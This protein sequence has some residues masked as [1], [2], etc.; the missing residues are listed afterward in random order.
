MA[1]TDDVRKADQRGRAALKRY[2]HAVAA[3]FASGKVTIK[4]SNGAEFSFPP[5]I[6]QGLENARAEQL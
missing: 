2:P 3:R 5:T 4:L 6:A 1:T